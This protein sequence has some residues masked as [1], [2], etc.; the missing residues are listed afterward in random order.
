M[1]PDASG[2][3][4]TPPME[5]Y[6]GYFIED[7]T[8]GQSAFFGKTVT[9]GDNQAFTLMTQNVSKTH[10]DSNFAMCP[11]DY[12]GALLACDEAGATVFDAHDAPLV[13]ADPE[14]RRRIV[15]AGTR[16]LAETLKRAVA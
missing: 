5:R 6:H 14:A 16:E 10:V 13:T 11:W 8:V 7:L 2:H 15:A 4:Q 3:R 1:S 9:D 12:L